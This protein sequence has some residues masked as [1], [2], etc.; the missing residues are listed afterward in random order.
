M[1]LTDRRP[2]EATAAPVPDRAEPRGFRPASRRRSRIAAGV[3]LA[4]IAIGGNVLLYTALDDTTSVLQLTRNV[5]AGEQVTIADLRTVEVDLDPTVPVVEADDIGLVI[6]QYATTY[7]AAGSLLFS[8]LVQADPLVTDGAGVVAVEL[9]SSLTP[10]GLL[11]RSQVQV[12]VDDDRGRTVI[13]GRV[14]AFGRDA[15]GATSGSVSIEVPL[16]AAAAVAAAEDVRIVLVDPAND[17]LR[18]ESG[19]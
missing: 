11:E 8:G 4:A 12:V 15:D 14:V 19:G 18:E 1:A 6:N 16:D 3:V 17:P 13:D 2:P 5:R 7:I 9:E 10:S